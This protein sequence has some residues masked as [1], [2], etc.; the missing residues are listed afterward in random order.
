MSKA[1]SEHSELE[2]KRLTEID[3]W[4]TNIEI[5]N[6]FILCFF[7]LRLLRSEI[8]IKFVAERKPAVSPSV[9]VGKLALK[10][11]LPFS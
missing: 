4:K 9:I 7:F 1:I 11:I 8:N 2:I 5:I 10:N 3:S 6:C